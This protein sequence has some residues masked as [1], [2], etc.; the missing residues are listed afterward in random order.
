[1]KNLRIK[2][3]TKKETTIST[4]TAAEVI[5]PNHAINALC[6]PYAIIVASVDTPKN[7]ANSIY[8]RNF[9]GLKT[10]HLFISQQNT[11]AKVN[12]IDVATA[13]RNARNVSLITTAGRPK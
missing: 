3:L 9:P 11:F 12:P 4:N 1:M 13:A 6:T 2:K 10:N 5:N 7:I 8:Q